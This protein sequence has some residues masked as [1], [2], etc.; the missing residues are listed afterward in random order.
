MDPFSFIATLLKWAE[1]VTILIDAL[2]GGTS[3][4]KLIASMK[5]AMLDEADQQMKAELGDGK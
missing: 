3:K 1:P 2:E 4:D 5:Q